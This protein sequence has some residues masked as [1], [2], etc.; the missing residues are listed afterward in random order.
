MTFAELRDAQPSM[1]QHAAD[2][3]LALA[4]ETEGCAED[5][6]VRGSNSLPDNWTDK[7]GTLAAGRLTDLDRA[8]RTASA[9]DHEARRRIGLVFSLMTGR[10]VHTGR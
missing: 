7:V 9:A 2:G 6:Y 4:K 5:I 10:A 8:G 3:W 1:W